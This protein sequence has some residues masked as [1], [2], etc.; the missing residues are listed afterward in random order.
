MIFVTTLFPLLSE[1]QFK[2]FLTKTEEKEKQ[3]NTITVIADQKSFLYKIFREVDA[4]ATEL[5][6]DDALLLSVKNQKILRTCFQLIIS[7]GFSR[8]LIP[9][10]GINLSKRCLSA[11]YLPAVN[12][13]DEDKYEILTKCTDFFTRCYSVPVL[14]NIILT[15]HLSDYLAALI[16]LSFAPLKK[17]GLY[18]NFTMTQELYEKIMK[19]QDLY[20]KVYENLVANCFQ[21][22]LMKELLVLQSVSDPFPPA[23]V[24]RVIAREMT[25]RLLAPGGLLSLIRCFIES[26]GMDTG[27]EWK[28]IDLICKIVAAKHGNNS[29]IENL[30]NITSQLK[31][32]LSLKNIHYLS[33]AVACVLSLNEKYPQSEAVQVL[34]QENFQTLVYDELVL[35]PFLPGTIALSA[36]EVERAVNVLHACVCGNNLKRPVALLQPN[37]YLLFMIGLKSVKDEDMNIKL[38]DI[39]LKILESLP[40]EEIGPQMTMLLFGKEKNEFANILIEEYEAG[41]A[42]KFVSNAVEYPKKDSLLYFIKLYKASS[43]TKYIQAVFEVSLH[44]V[45][46]LTEKRKLNMMDTFIGTPEDDPMLFDNSDERYLG[47]LQLL[48]EICTYPKVIATLK[49]HPQ[50]ILNFIEYF[51]MKNFGNS[52]DDECVTIALVLLNTILESTSSEENFKNMFHNIIPVLKKMA[53]NELGLN[54][55]LCKEALVLM[56]S[57]KLQQPETACAKAISDIFDTLLPVRAHG[58]IE[59]TKLIE[60]KDPE[61]ISKKHFIFCLFQVNI[62]R[63]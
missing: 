46:D 63:L 40:K 7:L 26:Y 56:T 3:A 15:L 47:I 28:K 35:R 8:C 30:C 25:R 34:V 62:S 18:G 58:I 13:S 55:M 51:L 1:T 22:I 49:E 27:F 53:D 52:D 50:G 37:L 19:D 2:S 11:N 38:K 57:N 43:N 24:K 36:Q 17:P 44:I 61:T 21:P 42:L 16:Q 48:T 23:F 32:I 9:G 6:N 41:V 39:L 4:V 45:I 5:K 12:L 60:V 14:K 20:T 29:E 59:L 31:Q 33:T 54:N 10:L